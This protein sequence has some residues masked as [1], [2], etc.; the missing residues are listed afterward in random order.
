MGLKQRL[1]PLK[2]RI[3]G[4][5]SLCPW[6]SLVKNLH[7]GTFRTQAPPLNIQV[8]KQSGGLH[9][10]CFGGKHE[11]WFPQTMVPNAEL[12]SE[13]LVTT[14]NHPSNPHFYLKGG[15]MLGAEDVVLDCGACEGFFTRQ[16]LD[17]G[18]KKIICVEPNPEMA[19]CLNASFPNE[20]AEGRLIVLP[21]ALGS[22]SG[23]ANFSASPGDAFSG[24]FDRSGSERVPI[25]TL[26]QLVMEYGTPTMIKM[27]LEGSE[28][29]A[30]RGGLELLEKYRPKLAVTTYHYPWD[31]AVVSSFLRGMN[32]PSFRVTSATMRGGNIPRPVMIHAWH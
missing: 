24:R 10:L 7:P 2:A 18:V 23:E 8:L 1:A 13:Y 22:L 19:A 20:I 30:L 16:A 6:E 21:V 27:D 25:V 15:V 17:L 3:L 26:D 12:W 4:N 32:Y 28:Y 11:F 9:L 14:W 31:H 29:E 5:A